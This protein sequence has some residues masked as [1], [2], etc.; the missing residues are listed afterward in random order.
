[1][2]IAVQTPNNISGILLMNVSGIAVQLNTTCSLTDHKTIGIVIYEATSFGLYSSN[3]SNC[4]YGLV[5]HNTTNTDLNKVTAMY[6][7]WEGIALSMATN[8]HIS[9]ITAVHNGGN[10]IYLHIMNDTYITSIT[11]SHNKLNGMALQSMNYT[12]ITNTTTT[13]NHWNGME[14]SHL[15]VTYIKNM[16]TINNRMTGMALHYT[17]YTC[18]TAI[19]NHVEGMY[20]Q[21]SLNIK[22]NE[23]AATQNGYTEFEVSQGQITLLSSTILIYSTSFKDISIP[24]TS[25]T[26]DPFSLPAII[27]L[28]DTD[29]HVSGCTF[30]GNSISAMR[31]HNSRITVSETLTFV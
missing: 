13:H 19:R 1:M 26:A 30:T 14:S 7:E 5:L 15:I 31:A 10:G 18:I 12:H 22:M 2:S 8:T 20:L 24:Y 3:A 28:Y 9:N 17:L 16:A 23:I 11:A 21:R 27:L 25:S 29:L 4:S 6:N